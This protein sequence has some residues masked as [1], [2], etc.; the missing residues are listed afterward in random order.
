MRCQGCRAERSTL[1]P[2]IL[3][4]VKACQGKV[5]VCHGVKVL[6]PD[7]CYGDSKIAAI[8]LAILLLSAV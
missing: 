6:S 8:L 1:K 3:V 4:S 2:N 7:L 5:V